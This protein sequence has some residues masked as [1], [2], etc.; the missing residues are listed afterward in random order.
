MTRLL[1]TAG[2]GVLAAVA[3][4]VGPAQAASSTSATQQADRHR[5]RDVVVGYYRSYRACDLAGRIGERFGK[6]DDYDCDY[7]RRGFDRRGV[8]ALEVEQRGWGG[9]WNGGWNR[10]GHHRGH[11]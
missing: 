5:D 2:M 1:T 9:G 11:R 6:W 10:P 4:G 8:F 7:Q 3:F